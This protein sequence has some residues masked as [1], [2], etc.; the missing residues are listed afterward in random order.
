MEEAYAISGGGNDEIDEHMALIYDANGRDEAAKEIYIGLLSHM[1]HPEIRH[2]LEKI[3]Q[4]SGQSMEDLNTAINRM[5]KDNAKP[6][7]ELKL[8]S[9]ADGEAISIADYRGKV[10]LLSFWHP[11]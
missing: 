4:E 2:H 7:P 3:V 9:L 10:V 1:E 8:P 6:V 5:R 11:T